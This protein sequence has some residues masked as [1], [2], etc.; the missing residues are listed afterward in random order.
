[1]NTSTSKSHTQRDEDIPETN[2]LR[3]TVADSGEVRESG[4]EIAFDSNPGIQTLSADTV[5][6]RPVLPRADSGTAKVAR[7]GA[8]IR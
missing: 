2:P 5:P 3:G 4:P 6:L 1:V 8:C 7:Q